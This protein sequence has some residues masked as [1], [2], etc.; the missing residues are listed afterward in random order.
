[1]ELFNPKALDLV[2]DDIPLWFTKWG[3]SLVIKSGL[4]KH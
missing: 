2:D 1:M 4:S 3:K